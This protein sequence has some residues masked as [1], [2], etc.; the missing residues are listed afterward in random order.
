MNPTWIEH[1]TQFLDSRDLVTS[2]L[3]KFLDNFA[4]HCD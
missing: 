3:P 4:C 1:I 2:P